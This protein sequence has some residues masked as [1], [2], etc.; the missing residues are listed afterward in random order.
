VALLKSMAGGPGIE[1]KKPRQTYV[2]QGLGCT[3]LKLPEM[4]HILSRFARESSRRHQAL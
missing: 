3:F 1:S 2:G 4:W